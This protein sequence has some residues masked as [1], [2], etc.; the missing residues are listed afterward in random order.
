MSDRDADTREQRHCD[1]IGYRHHGRINAQV[2]AHP[3]T[4]L[5]DAGKNQKHRQR[6]Q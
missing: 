3:K 4:V 5:Q 1:Q 2:C 6:Q